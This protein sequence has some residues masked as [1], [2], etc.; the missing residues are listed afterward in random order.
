MGTIDAIIGANGSSQNGSK[1]LGRTTMISRR[2][3]LTSTACAGAAV[4]APCAGA[5]ASL[6]EQHR[7]HHRAVPAGRS[8]RRARPRG[9]APSPGP[10]GPDRGDRIQARRV[11]PA[12][13]PPG[14]HLA[15]RRLH[16]DAG[17]HR[18]HPVGGG[19]PGHR[20]EGLRGDARAHAD[21]AGG[22]AVLHS[23]GQSVGAGEERRRTDRL[24]QGQSRQADL[25]L[26]RRRHR[27]ASLGRA[28]R[29]D[30]RGRSCCTCRIA[31]PG[32]R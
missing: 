19:E 16:A 28:V 25:R 15:G 6:S 22:G 7:A 29:P 4:L 31:A 32:R 13:R 24:R 10:V 30:G 14:H 8:D 23:G 3:F 18:R 26:L 11:G 2:A 17:V 20:A 5:G 1:L 27:V 9:R 21:L 12:R